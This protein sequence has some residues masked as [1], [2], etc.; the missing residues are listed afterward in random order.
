VTHPTDPATMQHA[1]RAPDEPVTLAEFVAARLDE[2]EL[3]A[4]QCH[5]QRWDFT[6]FSSREVRV[7]EDDGSLGRVV[8]YCR[9]GGDATEEFSRS[10]HIRHFDPARVLREVEAGR[11]LLA[12]WHEADSRRSD[13]A[14]DE[15]RAWL[16]DG[17]LADRAAVWSD[18]PEFGKLA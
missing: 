12:R 6:G 10:I 16:L 15:A 1:D 14:E 5:G 9:D 11:K 8:A 4:R 13:S 18:H 7:R 2:D 17:L 3:A